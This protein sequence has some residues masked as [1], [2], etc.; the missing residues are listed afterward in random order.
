M[1]WRLDTY[2]C[3]WVFHLKRSLNIRKNRMGVV[4]MQSVDCR[5]GGLHLGGAFDDL[6]C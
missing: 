2:G 6:Q 1:T 3:V 5:V 4:A